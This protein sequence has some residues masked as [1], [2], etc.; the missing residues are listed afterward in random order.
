M[1]HDQ[2]KFKNRY[3]IENY[4]LYVLYNIIIWLYEYCIYSVLYSTQIGTFLLFNNVVN[5][6]LFGDLCTLLPTSNNIAWV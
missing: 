6:C 2:W 3:N 4:S 5:E 1:V